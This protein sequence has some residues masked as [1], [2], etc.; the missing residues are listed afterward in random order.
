M[1]P[2]DLERMIKKS[3]WYFDHQTGSHRIYK[4]TLVVGIIV[5]PFHGSKELPKGP[6]KVFLKKPALNKIEMKKLNVVIEQG[7]DGF[8]AYVAEIDGCT[9]GGQLFQRRKGISCK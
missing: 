2:V 5:I 1:K 9:A 4:H 6:H 3:G 8:F 7:T